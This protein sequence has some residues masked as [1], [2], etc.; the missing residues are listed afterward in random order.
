MNEHTEQRQTDAGAA[1]SPHRALPTASLK[2]RVRSLRLPDPKINPPSTNKRLLAVFLVICLGLSGQVLYLWRENAQTSKQLA[3]FV[4]GDLAHAGDPGGRAASASTISSNSSSAVGAAKFAASGEVVLER[5]GYIIPAHQILISP[6]VSGMIESLNIEEGL[7]VQKGQVLA[8]LETIDYDADYRRSAGMYQGAWQRFLELYRGSRP[9]EIKQAK[10]RLDEMDAQKEQLYL[11]F[12]RNTRLTSNSAGAAH[13]YELSA[14]SYRAM[15]RKAE[16]MRQDYLM[17]LEGPRIEKVEAAWADVLQAEADMAKNKWRLENCSIRAPVTGTILVKRA[18]LGN[19]VNPIAMQGSTSLCEM[20]DL[21]D[22]EVD[23]NIEERDVAR[24]FKGQ[25]CK[26]RSEA[27]PDRVYDGIVSRLMPQADR[28][29]SAIPVRVKLAVPRDEEGVYMK[30][31]M[32]AVVSF[33][34][35]SQSKEAQARK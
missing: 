2:E 14:S 24:V 32:G 26:V 9:E 6:K 33:L 4:A 17:L 8:Q 19:L 29:K 5:K 27:F 7:R 34:K 3:D 22:L 12:K 15:E 13:D 21:S 31:E 20:A 10:A 23:L 11:D 30:P 25:L 16:Q 18:E 35:A 1:D 28:S